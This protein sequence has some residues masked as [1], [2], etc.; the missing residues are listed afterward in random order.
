M[1][2]SYGRI[3]GRGLGGRSEPETLVAIRS[4]P[5]MIKHYTKVMRTY[6]YARGI[7]APF[8]IGLTSEK[9][10]T[11]AVKEVG[12][13][14]CSRT[15]GMMTCCTLMGRE[16]NVEWR[17][18]ICALAVELFTCFGNDRPSFPSYFGQWTTEPS[19][20]ACVANNG[21]LEKLRWHGFSSVVGNRLPRS[22]IIVLLTYAA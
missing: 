16:T 22:N 2:R 21:P 6:T 18:V 5:V 19:F 8:L 20:V 4:M 12:R 17:S 15:P 7:E 9:G 1:R 3:S 10:N 14:N 11:N 13:V